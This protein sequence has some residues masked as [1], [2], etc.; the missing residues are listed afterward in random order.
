MVGKRVAFWCR[1][2]LAA[3]TLGTA[4]PAIA[5]SNDAERTIR[6]DQPG[7]TIDPNIYGQFV[8]HLGRSVYEGYGS[9]RMRR[10]P[11]PAVSA[12]TSSPRFARSGCR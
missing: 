1:G 11:T 8:E 3:A 4:A 10:P 6:T 5:Q 7:P 2:L 12:T 9:A